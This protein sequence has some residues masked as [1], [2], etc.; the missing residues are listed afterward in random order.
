[1][2]RLRVRQ[3]GN[4]KK[5]HLGLYVK[6]VL[7]RE[8]M[9]V[10]SVLSIVLWRRAKRLAKRRLAKKFLICALAAAIKV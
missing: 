7:E 3:I 9:R 4:V 2:T 10:F 5:R 8:Q 6:H 1:M